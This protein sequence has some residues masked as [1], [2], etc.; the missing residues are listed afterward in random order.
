MQTGMLDA[1]NLE[2]SNWNLKFQIIFSRFDVSIDASNLEKINWSIPHVDPRQVVVFFKQRNL[3]STCGPQTYQLSTTYGSQT[4]KDSNQY[5]LVTK[6]NTELERFGCWFISN[7][8]LTLKKTNCQLISD[9]RLNLSLDNIIFNMK[10][11][12]LVQQYCLWDLIVDGNLT[13]NIH[14]NTISRT[15]S[16]SI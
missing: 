14:I 15:I 5:D 6:C 16:K 7:C 1:S 8:L 13:Y 12:Q 2:T 4:G 9:R 3:R 11:L 10:R